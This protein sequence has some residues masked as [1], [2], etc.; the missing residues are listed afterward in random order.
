ML[1][2][3]SPALVINQICLVYSL[4]LFLFT[5]LFSFIVHPS[6]SEMFCSFFVRWKFQF[7]SI[8]GESFNLRCFHFFHIPISE[9]ISSYVN[10][11]K[12]VAHSMGNLHL[13]MIRSMYTFGN[14]NETI[15]IATRNILNLLNRKM[16]RKIERKNGSIYTTNI[17]SSFVEPRTVYVSKQ[18][19]LKWNGKIVY[20]FGALF[21]HDKK[22]Q[23][24]FAIRKDV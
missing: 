14:I 24:D 1:Q 10:Q 6:A 8:Q 13:L 21:L 4:R 2:F 15:K 12:Q 9:T 7:I 20:F 19:W 3:L 22:W 18:G 17:M 23:C 11:I 16:K 5:Y